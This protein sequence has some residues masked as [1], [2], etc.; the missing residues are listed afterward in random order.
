M[1]TGRCPAADQCLDDTGCPAGQACDGGF[2][3]H[4]GSRA[5][6]CGVGE[7]HFGWDSVEIPPA[8]RAR[9]V[10][11][12]DCIRKLGKTI[13]IEAHA[14]N[15]GSDEFNIL[16]TDRRGAA[17]QKLLVDAGVPQARLQVL[18][19]GSLEATG[20][21]EAGRAQDRRVVLI[22]L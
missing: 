22:I 9:L 4:F 6:V 5:G 2:C 11:G 18:A 16:L 17:V 15:V 19:K 7:L 10:A 21:D 13:L 14:D 12:A 3:V 1:E 8:A 20:T